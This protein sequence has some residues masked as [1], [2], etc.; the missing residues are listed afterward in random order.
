MP[1]RAGIEWPA[2]DAAARVLGA[3]GSGGALSRAGLRVLSMLYGAGVRSRNVAYDRGWLRARRASIPVISIGNLVAGGAGKTPFTRWLAGEIEARGKRV[4]VLHGGYGSDEPALHREWQTSTFVF[5]ERDRVRAAREAA[6]SGADVAILDDAF[7]HRRLARDLD[8]VLV[9]AETR[10]TRLLP[11]GPLREP[12]PSLRRADL[13]VITRKTASPAEARALAEHLELRYAKPYAIAALLP[14]ALR[15][16]AGAPS[17]EAPG[18]AL[19]VS[20]IARPDLL[21]EQLQSLGMAVDRMLAYPD[22]YEYRKSDGARI[23]AA[24]GEHAI[25]CTEKDAVK[26]A[27]LVDKGKLWILQQKVVVEEG[28]DRIINMLERVL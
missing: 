1:M 27:A 16:A 8:I 13:V 21:L 7:Q 20:A 22:H 17:T 26:L 18:N 11:A 28:K 12:E 25:V 5:E 15:N 19:V 6:A 9:P 14:A 4:A 10:S 23:M 24:A 2:G 3:S